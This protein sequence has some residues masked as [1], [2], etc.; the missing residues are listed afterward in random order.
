MLSFLG[1]VI[2]AIGEY[3]YEYNESLC[4]SNQAPPG[5]YIGVMCFGAFSVFFGLLGF[6][7]LLHEHKYAMQAHAGFGIVLVII[8]FVMFGAVIAGRSAAI[9]AIE[10]SACYD[11]MKYLPETFW[12]VALGC[13]KY[14]GY[15]DAA[16]QV[17]DL[18]TSAY[19]TANNG[20]A[21]ELSTVTCPYKDGIAYAWEANEGGDRIGA[22]GTPVALY[23]CLNRDCCDALGA[24][25]GEYAIYFQAVIGLIATMKA[26]NVV[27]MIWF[28]DHLGPPPKKGKPK[29]PKLHPGRGGNFVLKVRECSTGRRRGV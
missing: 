5:G 28:A 27:L 13:G 7:C 15:I 14:D 1:C 23:G 10:G 26:I 9:D 3:G 25:L 8:W 11:I 6:I 18:E 29:P 4:P 19:V 16:P 22:S 21:G 24:M 20:G 12:Q 17:W 2:I